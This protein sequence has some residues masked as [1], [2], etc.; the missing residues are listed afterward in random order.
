MERIKEIL[1]HLAVLADQMDKS[2]EELK[3]AKNAWAARFC[4]ENKILWTAAEGLCFYGCFT[5]KEKA[6]ATIPQLVAYFSQR[7]ETMGMIGSVSVP[8][9][10]VP[11]KVLLT[12]N[13]PADV[14]YWRS[15]RQHQ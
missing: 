12:Y 14:D 15:I 8:S 10:D 3:D 4:N 11:L 5:T 2:E 6:D 9:E 13:Q 1:Q 7:G